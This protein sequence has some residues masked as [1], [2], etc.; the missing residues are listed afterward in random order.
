MNLL[1]NPFCILGCSVRDS[2]Q[3]IS[4]LIDEKSLELDEEVIPNFKNTLL[5]PR[6]RVSTEIAWLPSVDQNALV[7]YLLSLKINHLI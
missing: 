4:N 3:T 5:N 2:R 6:T 7:N 1:E